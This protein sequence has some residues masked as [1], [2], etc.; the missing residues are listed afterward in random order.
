MLR[1]LVLLMLSMAA[2]AHAGRYEQ[3]IRKVAAHPGPPMKIVAAAL[4]G[5]ASDEAFVGGGV[6]KDGTVV[7]IGQSVGP[8]FPDEGVNVQT[9]GPDERGERVA[10]KPDKKGRVSNAA[11]VD[12][13]R[14]M[15][16]GF[17]L[18]WNPEQKKVL[19]ASRFGFGV[20]SA[21]D[22]GVSPD[23]SIFLVGRCDAEKLRR[24]AAGGG[25]LVVTDVGNAAAGF[26]D[27]YV[28]RLD[29]SGTKLDWVHILRG[30]GGT[31]T[32]LLRIT[33]DAIYVDLNGVRAISRDGRQA[34]DLKVPGHSDRHG[35][36]VSP[37]G[38]LIVH[39]GD[40]N[41]STGREPY[42]NP[43]LH[44]YDGKGNRI[45]T[46][47]NWDSKR[48][49]ADQYRLVSDSSPRRQTF[50]PKGRLVIA[51]WSDGGNTVFNRQ[52]KDLD[53][54]HGQ[55][56]GKFIDSAWG[57]NVGSLCT[58]MAIEP[59]TWQVRDGTLWIS[60]VPDD[61]ETFGKSVGKP[62]NA[63]VDS[64]GFLDD[65][66]LAIAGTAATGIIE[67]PDALYRYPGKGRFGG[68]YLSIL[69][70]DYRNLRFSTYLPDVEHV[71]IIPAGKRLLVVGLAKRDEA[72]ECRA[73]LVEA[74][75]AFASGKT[76]AW[77]L[78]LED[79]SG[80]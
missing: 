66:S 72:G 17:V 15:T 52:P 79:A 14:P 63:S 62:N 37:D 4:F 45:E 20:A 12:A 10:P 59:K 13:M 29:P 40:R 23:G 39:G 69:T 47:W 33:E 49:G 2:T 5:S 61:A 42:R 1:W 7:L 44:V 71:R 28:A 53:S 3:Y 78:L 60:F 18:R 25:K 51:G 30:V 22:G 68:W 67:T 26:G 36:A 16:A 70:P 46:L 8:E 27:G 73:P 21:G 77:V 19:S 76:D 58:I 54:A 56:K 75:S 32:R 43:Y 24:L 48:V 38:T 65:G 11:L 34:V 31:E 55:F 35:S 80:N 74:K 41:T 50:D 57:M 64:L 6:Q 9:F